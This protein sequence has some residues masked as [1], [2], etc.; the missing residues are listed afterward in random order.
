MLKWARARWWRIVL[1][2]SI[3]PFAFVLWRQELVFQREFDPVALWPRFAA[4]VLTGLAMGLPFRFGLYG[5]ALGPVALVAYAF[6]LGTYLTVRALIFG[7][8]GG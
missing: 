7:D 6:L 8:R 3:M 2:I 5:A 1:S 4:A